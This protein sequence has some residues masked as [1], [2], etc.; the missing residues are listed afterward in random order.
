MVALLVVLV[1]LSAS[2]AQAPQTPQPPP[3]SGRISGVVTRQDTGRPLADVTVR[4]VRWEGGFGQQIPAARTGPDGRFVLEHLRAGEYGLTFSAELFVTLQFGQKLPQDSARRIDLKDGVHFEKADI[5]LPPTTAI[6]G[7]LLDEFGDPAPGV[8]VQVSQVVFAA[9]KRRLMPVGSGALPPR[10]TDDLGR[11]RIFNLPSGDYY[12]M[13]LA[14]PFAGPDDPSGFAVT[15]FPGTRVPME[16]KPV[17]L[18]VGRDVTG[19]TMQ[20]TPAPMSTVS[21]VVVDENDQPIA[22]GTIMLLP[23]SGDDVR[24]IL[25]GRVATGPDGA[26]TFRNVA[27]GTYV[28]QAYGRPVGGGNLGRSPFAAVPLALVE[29]ADLTGL[30]VSMPPGAAAR[31]RIVFEGDAPLPA[32][33]MVSP[34]AINFASAPVGGGPPNSVTNPDWTFEVGNM[35]G[36]RVIDVNIGGSSQ[37]ILKKVTRKGL[38]LTDEPV[39]FR[40]GDVNDLEITLSSRAATLTGQVTDTDGSAADNTV[41]LFSADPAKWAYPSRYFGIARPTPQGTFVI[42]GLRP[43]EYLAA[44]L[45]IVQGT[46]WQDPEYLQQLVGVATRV[47]ISEGGTASVALTVVRR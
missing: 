41:V 39:D 18:D 36:L 12:V 13:A 35:S 30:R 27:P 21:G 40:D 44:A 4:A 6:E 38:D 3:P 37:W 8:V 2:G 7:R 43:G 23:T 47:S 25:M 5:A 24:A 22:G 32:R 34:R 46:D 31:G 29:G 26:F 10:P 19:L 15:Y 42:R 11:F 20:L 16:A 45:P 14:G 9:G 28:I 33:V 17:R 1:T